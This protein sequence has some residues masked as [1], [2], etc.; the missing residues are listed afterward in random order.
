MTPNPGDN[1]SDRCD[2]LSALSDE[3]LA[4][5]YRSGHLSVSYASELIYR[6]F[7]LIKSKAASMCS[8]PSAYDDLV[9]EGL[10][11]LL[12]AVRCYRDDR[13]AGF[14]TFASVCIANRIKSAAAKLERQQLSEEE[15]GDERAE[16]NITPESIIIRRELVSELY[17]SLTPL[18]YDVFRYYSV[19]LNSREA[20]ERLGI[21]EK[22]AENAIT[23]VRKKLK[24]K[25]DKCG[26]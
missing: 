24:G 25:L 11:G 17:G 2:G 12:N 13:G 4:E 19:G 6:Y 7:G 5:K 3:E 8:N 22:S 10:L 26:D 18:E 23:R 9:Q 16:D 14:A 15:G 20:A 21:T 1:N